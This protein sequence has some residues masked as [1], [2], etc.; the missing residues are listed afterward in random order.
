LLQI[1]Q[2]QWD[3]TFSEHSYGFRPG[4]SG[5]GPGAT[6]HSRGLQHRR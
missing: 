1:L 5:R 3:P 2:E 6:I 4:R